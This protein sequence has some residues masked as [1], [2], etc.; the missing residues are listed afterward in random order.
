METKLNHLLANITVEYHKLQNLHWYIAGSDFFQVHAKLEELYD[1]LLPIID[2]VAETIL[3]L[4]G[5]PIASMS[6]VLSMASIKERNDAPVRSTEVFQIVLADFSALL[7]EVTTIKVAAD[8]ESNHLVSALMDD[9]IASLSKA[10][11]MIRQ[12]RA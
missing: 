7:D 9:Y 4:G 8:N 2:D 5:K 10:I 12:Y 11:W 6:E 1:S 3:Q